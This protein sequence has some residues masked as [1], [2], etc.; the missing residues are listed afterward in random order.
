MGANRRTIHPVTEE[1]PTVLKAGTD[2]IE[3]NG[4]SEEKVVD[5]RPTCGEKTKRWFHKYFLEGTV[6][7]LTL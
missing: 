7:P 1:E 4:L 5:V 3:P 6:F 2:Y